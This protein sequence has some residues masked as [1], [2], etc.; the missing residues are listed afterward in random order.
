MQEQGRSQKRNSKAATAG[1][2]VFWIAV[3][4]IAAAMIVFLTQP[5]FRVYGSVM[6]PTLTDG[7]VVIAVRDTSPKRGEVVAIEYNSKLLIRRVIATAGETVSIDSSGN[8]TVSG[9]K[10]DEPYAS[11]IG[12][13]AGTSEYPLTVPDGTVFVLSD[14][15]G[16]GADSRM[17]EIGC[18]PC[19]SVQGRIVLRIWPGNRIGVIR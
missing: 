9:T 5:V 7:D 3:V 19:D 18:L 10:L 11:G 13:G 16:N 2:L 17:Q 12:S 4:C 6:S 15:R 8:I 14:S 1:R